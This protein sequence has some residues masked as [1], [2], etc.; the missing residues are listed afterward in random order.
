MTLEEL[1]ELT[2]GSN[3]EKFDK[4]EKEVYLKDHSRSWDKDSPKNAAIKF[5]ARR[6]KYWK[7]GL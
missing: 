6:G 5:D 3:P 2:G 4:K 7:P 1:I